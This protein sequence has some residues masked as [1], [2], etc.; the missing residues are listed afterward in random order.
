M[1]ILAVAM[2]AAAASASSSAGLLAV[3]TAAEQDMTCLLQVSIEQGPGAATPV[4]PAPPAAVEQDP[5]RSWWSWLRPARRGTD[6]DRTRHRRRHDSFGMPILAALRSPR[7]S[8]LKGERADT[9]YLGDDDTKTSTQKMLTQPYGIFVKVLFLVCFIFTGLASAVAFY[10]M[11]LHWR[12]GCQMS[13]SQWPHERAMR[14][15]NQFL[16]VPLF[17][18]TGC[19]SLLTLDLKPV[20]EAAES[21]LL[22]FSTTQMMIH[23]QGLAGGPYSLHK[24][25]ESNFWSGDQYKGNYRTQ[26]PCCFQRVCIP[27]APPSMTDLEVLRGRFKVF[28]VGTFVIAALSMALGMEDQF[29]IVDDETARPRWL[30]IETEEIMLFLIFW[31]VLFLLIGVSAMAGTMRLMQNICPSSYSWHI[32]CVRSYAQVTFIGLRIVPRLLTRLPITNVA[33]LDLTLANGYTLDDEDLRRAVASAVV[34]F[35]SFLVAIAAYLA[36]PVDK[37][38]YPNVFGEGCAETDVFAVDR[39]KFCPFCGS[40]DITYTTAKGKP[41]EEAPPQAY[42][43]GIDTLDCPKCKSDCIPLELSVRREGPTQ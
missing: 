12:I 23:L 21:T 33:G 10:A 6:K 15:I 17:A 9:I 1:P 18:A 5:P 42:I 16:S 13:G 24:R 31:D 38:S 3:D 20:W 26:I 34:C 19:V 4:R 22:V 30:R 27:E 28:Q 7:D 37:A 11:Y 43:P 32:E 25:I 14:R 8:L 40:R 36:Y 2:L 29:G 41:G 39:I 35:S